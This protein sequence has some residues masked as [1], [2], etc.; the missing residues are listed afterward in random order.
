MEA[1][2]DTPGVLLLILRSYVNACYYL[3]LSIICEICAT[4]FSAKI[5][6]SRETDRGLYEVPFSW[7][8]SLCCMT[9]DQKLSSGCCPFPVP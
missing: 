6:R 9:W 2:D 5:S 4:I 3:I 8:F 1:F 7:S